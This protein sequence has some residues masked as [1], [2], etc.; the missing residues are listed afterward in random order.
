M[1]KLFGNKEFYKKVLLIAIPI[2]V[3]NGITNFVGMLDN[4]MIGQM[5]TDQMSGVAITN[6]LIFVFNVC[7]FGG[8]SGAGIF[9]AQ[10]F[11]KGDFEGV[12]NAFRFKIYAS[13]LICGIS[14]FIFGT[15]SKPLISLYLHKANEIGS[16]E[17]TLFYG[18]QY[19]FIMLIGLIPFVISQI[20]ASTLRECGQ[21]IVPMLAGFVAVIVNLIFN[22][23]LIFGNF[24]AP[25]LG[26]SGA[27]IATV[28][29]RFAETAII[30]AWTHK[31]PEKNKFIIGIYRT[32]KIPVSFV[33]NILGKGVSLMV[34][35]FF[36]S[37]GM[38][39]ITQCYA[40]R[41]LDVVAA[42][43]ITST[44]N[45]VFNI[46]FIALGGAVSI[47]VGQL[48]GAG[49]LQE[50]RETDTKLIAFSVC[51][52]IVVGTVMALFSNIFPSIYKTE[53]IVK[54]YASKFILITAVALPLQAFTHSCYFTLRSGG[55][56]FITLLFDSVYTWVFVIPIVFVLTHFSGVSII[57]V[58][59]IIQFSEIVKCLIGFFMVKKGS[60]L[61]NI[62]T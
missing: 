34:N 56:T 24:G 43:N 19:L 50:A 52:C 7:I 61:Q 47:M 17:D 62:V 38:A 14:F 37:V 45:N 11:G 39:T 40:F 33:K 59:F 12:R 49:K 22:Y 27:A 6:Q 5:G 30:V 60:W 15:C 21:T 54:E 46:V 16:I 18:Q 29:A 44:L 32:M 36:W 58:Y 23:I 2:M 1:K 8:I 57:W 10:F 35:E 3:Q 51:C 53:D 31:N 13:T 20:Y 48:L 25:K 55:K 26:A 4:I 9:G 28:I 42:L 41:G